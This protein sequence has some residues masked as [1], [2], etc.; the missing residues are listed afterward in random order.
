MAKNKNSKPKQQ[1]KQKKN[2]GK[3]MRAKATGLDGD[4]ARYADLLANPCDA[5]LAH[6][7][8]SGGDGGYLVRT[9]SILNY[10]TAAGSSNQGYIHWIPNAISDSDREMLGNS[11]GV[12]WG[13][14][15]ATFLGD[16]APGKTFLKNSAST[17]RCVAACM[18]ISYSGAE[19]NRAG[20]VYYG[21]TTGG[22]IQL[23][24][25]YSPDQV[26][27]GLTH[28]ER[29]PS[30]EI[31]IIW[32]PTDADQI[33]RSPDTLLAVSEGDRMGALTVAFKGLPDTVG[34]MVRFFAVYEWQP[35]PAGGI[36][37][38]QASRA[39]SRNSLDDVLNALARK[40]FSW[41][42]SS[43]LSVARTALTGGTNYFAR[44]G[45]RMLTQ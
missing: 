18:K 29:T 9:Q 7:T 38:S 26:A 17:F 10:P 15:T 3:P 33:L 35:E 1:Q 44:E 2:V 41:M 31:E 8:F 21:N 4:G 23:G 24:N 40:G 16:Y 34:L 32:K 12:A 28:G 13:A 37:Q 39:M 25:G 19:L 43:A 36:T 11:T 27:T 6:P 5:P 45:I 22:Y 20:M 30:G 42:R 14:A